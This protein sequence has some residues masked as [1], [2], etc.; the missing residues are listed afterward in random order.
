MNGYAVLFLCSWCNSD[1]CSTRDI[2]GNIKNHPGLPELGSF[3]SACGLVGGFNQQS[4]INSA[5]SKAV[6]IIG[7][8]RE[9][10]NL[11]KRPFDTIKLVW[12]SMA[13]FEAVRRVYIICDTFRWFRIGAQT[14]RIILSTIKGFYAKSHSTSVSVAYDA[15][16]SW[17]CW[18]T[19]VRRGSIKGEYILGYHAA[20]KSGAML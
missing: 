7:I 17:T 5:S 8:G 3:S 15:M 20:S 14:T 19:N 9:P 11:I 6:R 13:R 18:R 16:S 1:Q 2:P 12:Y 10:I 4:Q